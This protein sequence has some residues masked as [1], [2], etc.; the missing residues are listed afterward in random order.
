MKNRN[1]Y[2]NGLLSIALLAGVAAG[3]LIFSASTTQAVDKVTIC[4]AD[5]KDG[6][7]KFSTITVAPFFFISA[8]AIAA[9]FDGS[10]T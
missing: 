2:R 6:T 3:V 4:H 7:L 5:G 1:G 9:V 8:I 10:T